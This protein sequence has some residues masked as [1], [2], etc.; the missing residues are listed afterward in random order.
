MSEARPAVVPLAS[1]AASEVAA[2]H[3]RYL[4]TPFR[5]HSGRKLLELYYDAFAHTEDA[6]CLVATV[7]GQI[8]GFACVMRRLRNVHRTLLRRAPLRLAWWAAA[9]VAQQPRLLA[10]LF[11]RFR[12]AEPTGG[13]QWRR[14]DEWQ[15]WWP[16][17]PLVVAEPFRKHG[18]ADLLMRAVLEEAKRRGIKGLIGTSE[19]SNAQSRVN[20]VRN[21]YT[22]V[23]RD[24]EYVVFVKPIDPQ[25]TCQLEPSR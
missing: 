14:P 12:G 2:L 19:R 13:L 17:R 3:L 23:W 9:Q 21:G 10:D 6:F 15:E 8:A 16:Y 1:V 4:V 7:D 18:I 20:L 22:E 24:D 5:G 11:R 25:P